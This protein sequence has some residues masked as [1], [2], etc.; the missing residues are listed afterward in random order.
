[1]EIPLHGAVG[2]VTGS[3]HE[4][5]PSAD[6]AILINCGLFQGAETSGKGANA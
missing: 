6:D 3:G 4:L 2:G 5:R 1:M